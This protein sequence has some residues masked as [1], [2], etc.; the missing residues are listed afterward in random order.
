MRITSSALATIV[1][2]TL[3]GTASAEAQRYYARERVGTAAASAP[4]AP[5][6]RNLTCS[7]LKQNIWNSSQKL[8]VVRQT[9][10]M[11]NATTAAAWCTSQAI[12][13]TDGACLYNAGN[14]YLVTN[15]TLTDIGNPGVYAATCS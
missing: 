7:A 5:V 11:T 4:A 15:Y 9:T 8:V 6:A 1:I 13:M 12:A 2:A 10:G 14:A 3:M